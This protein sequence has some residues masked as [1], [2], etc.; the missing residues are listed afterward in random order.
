MS[1]NATGPSETWKPVPGF[2]GRYEVSD[3]GR[4]RSLDRVTMRR[5]IDGTVRGLPV[6]GR[7]RVSHAKASGHMALVLGKKTR[8]Y[9]HD[10]VLRAFIG[11]PPVGCEC[12]HLNG[13]PADNRLVNLAWGTR[14]RNVQDKKWHG[15]PQKLTVVQVMAIKAALKTPYRGLGNELAARY[16]VARCTI[17]DIKKGRTH[18]DV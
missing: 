1:A 11:P 12:R 3:F 17:D 10:L 15:S 2:E 13:N 14:G 18:V 5:F 4:V 7:I 8:R 6:H 16:G 9:V